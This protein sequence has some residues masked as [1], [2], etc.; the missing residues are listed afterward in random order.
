MSMRANTLRLCAV[1]AVCA[2]AG[3]V[4]AQHTGTV[5]V[6]VERIENP[7]LANVSPGGATVLRLIPNYAFE[8]EGDRTRSRFT[9]GAVIERSSNT[10]LLASRE[11]PSI[12]YTWAYTWPTSSLELRANLAEA[13]TRNTELRDLGRV[14]VDSRERSFVTGATWNKELTA[15]T[16][17]ILGAENNK[18]SYD[19]PLLED[20]REQTVSS[21]LSWAASERT[22]YY[23]EPSYGRLTPSD[24]GPVSTLNRWRVGMVGEL[25][26]D[27]SLT[28][29]VGQARTGHAQRST[30]GVGALLLAYSGSR[31]SSELE[32][33]RDMDAFGSSIGGTSGYLRTEVLRLRVGYQL[34][35][36]A[37]LTASTTRSRSAGFAGGVGHVTGLMLENELGTNWSSTLGVEDRRSRDVVGVSGKGWAVRA[38][39]VYLFTGR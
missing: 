14:T 5:A 23:V 7:L 2:G 26:P 11:Y 36:S 17:L 37:S 9:L 18:V 4:H 1:A 8:T 10:Q 16:R 22:T 27:W 25:A 28:A 29:S 15:R 30:N 34:T 6:E 20:F 21:R 39:L 3:A 24:A 12:G 38:G 35:E 13:A 33:A 32:W 31:L 19:S